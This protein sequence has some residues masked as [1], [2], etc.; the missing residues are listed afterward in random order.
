MNYA[1]AEQTVTVS[2]ATTVL[3]LEGTAWELAYYYDG[4]GAMVAV[5]E[6]TK[7]TAVFNNSLGKL[8]GAACN[9]YNAGYTVN[10]NNLTID[11]PTATALTC[12]TPPGVMQQEA[13]YLSLLPTTSSYKIMGD[14]LQ[15]IKTEDG[16]ETVLLEY[17]AVQ[18]TPY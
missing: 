1:T 12:S 4:T 9:D 3:P 8:A 15:L 17:E 5:L 11:I 10:G 13:A 16:Q 14:V 2:P 7:I 6:S 18:A